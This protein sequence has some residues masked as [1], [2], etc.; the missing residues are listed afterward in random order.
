ME[1]CKPTWLNYVWS[2]HSPGSHQV[3]ILDLLYFFFFFLAALGLSYS[4]R[5]LQC[6]MQD[7]L[8]AVCDLLAA[9]CR[10]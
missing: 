9:A 10:I 5:D 1:M 8:A 4:M 7:L 2:L 3:G 6:G